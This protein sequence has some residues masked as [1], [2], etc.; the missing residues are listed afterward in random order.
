MWQKFINQV[1]VRIDLTHTWDTEKWTPTL[2][3][4]E[5]QNH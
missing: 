5:N 4:D 2:L 3:A 1:E